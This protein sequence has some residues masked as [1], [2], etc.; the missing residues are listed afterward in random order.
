MPIKADHL[1]AENDGLGSCR[2]TIE[3]HPR[4]ATK[5]LISRNYRNSRASA[6]ENRQGMEYQALGQMGTESPA[7]VPQPAGR[8]APDVFL[9]C[10]DV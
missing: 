5:A 10:S 4:A 8:L 3:L 6:T 2:S 9:L 1:D 7:K